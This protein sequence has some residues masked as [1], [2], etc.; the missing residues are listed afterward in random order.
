MI[1][2]WVY[3]PTDIFISLF[4]TIQKKML[5][6]SCI[7]SSGRQISWTMIFLNEIILFSSSFFFFIVVFLITRVLLPC[8]RGWKKNVFQTRVL[9][10]CYCGRKKNVF[11]THLIRKHHWKEIDSKCSFIKK[12][13][14]DGYLSPAL[15]E[16]L[17]NRC[18]TANRLNIVVQE[19]TCQ[20]DFLFSK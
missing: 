11:Q 4:L 16:I 9:L 1:W 17:L 20:P 15:N 19:S 12:C 10:P 13:W 6:Q 7:F 14:Y 8:Y 3:R 2:S 5:G 18:W